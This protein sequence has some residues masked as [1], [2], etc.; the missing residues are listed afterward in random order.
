MSGCGKIWRIFTNVKHRLSSKDPIQVGPNFHR[1]RQISFFRN[2]KR[3]KLHGLITMTCRQNPIADRRHG[4]T[5][6]FGGNLAAPFTSA[7]ISALL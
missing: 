2:D 5:Q 3:G 6:V 4:Q 1:Y 7:S